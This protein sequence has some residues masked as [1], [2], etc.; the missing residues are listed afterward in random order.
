MP[1]WHSDFP[2]VVLWS[3]KS[4]CTT[5]LKWFLQHTGR[6]DEAIAFSTWVHNYRKQKMCLAPGYV[7]GCARLFTDSA[8]D[9]HIAKL[10]RDPAERAVS[11]YLHLLRFGGGKQQSGLAA[12]VE[13]WKE[14]TGL[15]T[16]SG[17]SLRQFLA[18]VIDEQLQRHPLNLHFAPQYDE[19]QDPYVGTY[20]RLEDLPAALPTLEE[21]FHL[22]HVDWRP[23]SHSHH[24]NRPTESHGWPATPAAFAADQELL[25]ELGT[26]AAKA[27]LDKETRALIRS[28]YRR[29]YEAYGQHYE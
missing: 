17:I 2:I 13:H 19:L 5:I 28:A 12:A 15:A 11:S 14:S 10:I 9:K 6:L 23:L 8:S 26:P 4:G 3:A 25:T 22:P 29:D 7:E 1:L 16:Q 24:H 18:F 21:R 27:F 20:I